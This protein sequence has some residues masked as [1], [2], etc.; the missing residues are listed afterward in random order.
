MPWIGENERG[1]IHPCHGS[2]DNDIAAILYRN[3]PPEQVTTLKGIETA[4]GQ[5]G[6]K[7]AGQSLAE[8]FGADLRS[9]ESL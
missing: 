8:F 1:S 7:K 3:M 5:P 9:S 2:T 6:A 4:I